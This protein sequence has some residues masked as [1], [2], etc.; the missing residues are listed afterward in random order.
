MDRGHGHLR[1]VIKGGLASALAIA[2]LVAFA[3]T[4][5]AHDNSVT[6]SP[7]CNSPLGSGV[8]VKW[9]IANDYGVS[10]TGTVASVDGG[11]ATL[12]ATSYSIGPNG[13]KVLTQTLTAAEVTSIGSTDTLTIHSNWSDGYPV[14]VGKPYLVDTGTYSFSQL[15]CSAP[16]GKIA[17]HIYLCDNGGNQT[18]TEVSGGTL[19]ATGPQTVT[20]QS[21]PISP[22]VPVLA[23][24]YTMTA[25]P[26]TGYKL[27][28]CHGTSTPNGGGTSATES[29]TVPSAG[30]GTGY[31]YVTP[32]TQTIAGDIY[33]CGS[34]TEVPG[35]TLGAT[36]PQTV[37]TQANPLAPMNVKAGSYTMTATAPAGYLLVVCGGSSTPNGSGSSATESV[38]VPSGGAG[39]G[40]FYVQAFAPKLTIVK[41]STT[42]SVTN[43]GDTINY[44]YVV[45]NT[46]NVPLTSVGV[47][48]L[49]ISPAG[50]LTTG[51]TCTGLTNPSSSCTTSSS[52]T[53]APG[54]IATFTATYNVTLSDLNNGSINDTSKATGTN[55]SPLTGTTTA[56]SNEVSVPVNQQPK[57]VITKATTTTSVAHVGDTVNYSFTV[58]NEGNVTLTGVGVTDLPISPAGLTTSPTCTGLT[59]PSAAC[60]TSSSTT[61]APG[62]VATFTASYSTTLADLNN[63]SINDKSSTSGTKPGG[64]STTAMS[65]EVTVPATQSPQLKI[66]KST[67]TTSVGNV[68]DTVNYSFTVTNEGI[69]TLTGVGVTDLPISPAGALTSGPICT[70]LT[71]PSASCTSSASTTLAP[72]QVATFSATYKATQA[73][74][75]NGS[76]NDTSKTTGTNPAP[77]GGTTTADSN[78]V[79]VPVVQSPKLSIVKSTTTLSVSSVGTVIPYT[80]TVTNSGNVTLTS[81]GV[82]D[83]PISP[84]GAL[85]TGP[86]CTGLT[87]PSSSCTTSS[88]T[89]L[90]PGQVATFTGTY[91]VTLADL[92]NG[93][94]NDTSKTTGTNPAPLGGT[95]TADS[96][97]V[98]VPTTQNPGLEIVKSSTTTSVSTVGTVVPYTFT[99]TNS[100]NV[101]LTGVNVTDLPISPAGALTSGPSCTGLTSPS[102]S[103]T[104]STSTTLFPGQVATFT[105]T[106]TVTQADLDNGSISDTSKTTGTNPESL[107]GSTTADSNEVTITAAQSPSISVVKTANVTTVSAVGQVVTYTFTV[108]NTGNVTL[109]NVDVTDAQASPS[110]DSSL[111]P[112]T[113]T[114]GTPGSITLAPAATDTCTADYTVTQADLTNGSLAD[115]VT[116]VGDPPNELPPVTDASSLSLTVTS[117]S[118]VKAASPDGGVT[119]G[120]TTPI[121]YTL[122]VK[123]NGTATT[124]DPIVV[125]DTA[126]TGTT[127]VS[128][129]PACATGGPPTCTVAVGSTGT[130]TWT[131]PAGV[132]PGASYTLIYS[133]T[134]NAS[135]ATGTITNTASWSGP[136]CGTPVVTTDIPQV[137]TV[138]TCPTNTVSTTVTAAPVTAPAATTPTTSTTTTTVPPKTNP[139]TTPAIAFTGALLTQEWM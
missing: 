51:P 111:G 15:N 66:V 2:G 129:S 13:S 105:G 27:V 77:L 57:L 104:S 10:E 40:V 90:A 95:T 74:L 29:V 89:T 87:N 24:G 88:S 135:D 83:L 128:G 32:I 136:S 65:N 16:M 49:P 126:P 119:A 44:K 107:G 20:T 56:D 116:V 4:A 125:T 97:E 46:G 61:L 76:I 19:G 34:T 99:V 21:N 103:C 39:A 93:T 96:N 91:K 110:L 78:E 70:G 48:D 18:S 9:T 41:S 102:A 17:G 8:T 124:T 33:L 1:S 94:I 82:T 52:T 101:T 131:I 53:L 30:T 133:V 60:T 81:V 80:F 25:A 134:A 38:T 68:G 64:G 23:G 42:T 55:P 79:S 92:D 45:T 73:D 112:I 115:T 118:V 37:T 67:T 71:S 5:S 47:T 75:D 12:D 35:G 109:S 132:A 85:T 63:G 22:P 120:S 122:T 127:L 11:L 6:P 58:T 123:N 86:T 130:I 7:S 54:Q 59:N 26:P 139:A 121:V 14:N 3:T 108:T 72:G 43:V 28:T 100:G 137:A 31:F 98:T 62:Q 138:T 69:V 36:G 113:C 114:T 50:A 84:A 106:Y 117:V